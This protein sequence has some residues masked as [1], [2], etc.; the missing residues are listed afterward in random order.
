MRSRIMFRCAL[1]GALLFGAAMAHADTLLWSD[2]F[3]S[4]TTGTFPNSG[5]WFIRPGA[6]GVGS[7]GQFISTNRANSGTRSFRMEGAQGLGVNIQKD[8]LLPG[9]SFAFEAMANTTRRDSRSVLVGFGTQDEIY[10]AVQFRHN[11]VVAARSGYGYTT[12]PVTFE[13]DT[14]YKLKIV[15]DLSAAAFDVYVDDVPVGQDLPIYPLP[16]P[17]DRVHLV[18]DNNGYGPDAPGFA[19]GGTVSYF[20]DAKFYDLSVSTDDDGDGVLNGADQC[21]DTLTGAVT[22]PANG[23]SL[24]QLVPC[25]GPIGGVTPWKNHGTYVSTL[26]HASQDF[27]R[28]GLITSDQRALIMSNAAAATCPH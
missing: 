7:G 24:A 13:A 4:Y 19:P 1:L 16:Q 5:G 14:W 10:A 21:A 28:K 11:G 3:E 27:V 17:I 26:S 9:E 15:V 23:C 6:P 12:L 20:D 2:D 25:D 18:V 8:I 22:D